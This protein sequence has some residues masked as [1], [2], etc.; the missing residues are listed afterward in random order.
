MHRYTRLAAYA[1]WAYSA[2]QGLMSSREH[3]EVIFASNPFLNVCDIVPNF[4]S[5]LPLH[6]WIPAIFGARGECNDNSW[7]FLNMGMASWMQ[8]LF[9]AYLVALILVIASSLY[10]KLQ[11]RN[12]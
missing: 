7:Q 3:L 5:F 6:E 4:P 9:I 8:I 1:I 12:K 10:A 11:Q 2:F